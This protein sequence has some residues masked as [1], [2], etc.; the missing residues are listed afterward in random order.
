MPADPVAATAFVA[1]GE[2][3]AG[4]MDAVARASAAFSSAGCTGGLVDGDAGGDA[5]GVVA[6]APGR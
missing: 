5:H 6:R 2:G 1:Q 3:T 4:G